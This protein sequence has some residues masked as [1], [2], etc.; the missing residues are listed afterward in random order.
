MASQQTGLFKQGMAALKA[1]KFAEAKKLF[2]EHEK[3]Q[4]TAQETLTLVKEAEAATVAGRFPEATSKFQQ[5]LDRNP[6]IVESHLGMARIAIYRRQV[7]EARVF[8]NAAV[9]LAPQNPLSW[10]F[11]GLVHEASGDLPGALPHLEKGAQLGRDNYLAQYNMGRLLLAQKK[12]GHGIPYLLRAVQ[13]AP[14]NPDPLIAVG[15]AQVEIKQLELALDSLTRATRVAPG[16]LDAWASLADVQFSQQRYKDALATLNAGLKAAG[17]HPALLEKAIACCMMLHDPVTAVTYS[18]RSLKKAPSYKQGWLNLARLAL[19]AGDG[20]KSISAARQLLTLDPQNWEAWFHLGDVYDSIRD[21]AQAI[22]AYQKA[23]K[24]AP[25]N[26][27]V[28]MNYATCLLQS[29][30]AP[31]WDEARRL[32]DKAAAVVPGGEFRVAYNLALAHVRLGDHFEALRLA[33]D[34]QARAAPNDPIRAEANKLERN[35]NE[36]R[37]S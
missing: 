26:W 29:A 14:R 35:L 3:K 22:D 4:G 13:L 37:A 30:D 24:G 6:A 15:F 19:M 36:K 31:K 27:K 25:D 32:L 33:K 20:D 9:R 1:Q 23:L 2:D 11:L 5:V 8:A 34:I 12:A 7:E 10:T 28:L 17:E 18:E 21:E 16:S